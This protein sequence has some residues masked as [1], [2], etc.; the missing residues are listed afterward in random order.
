MIRSIWWKV[1]LLILLV[2]GVSVGLRVFGIDLTQ[3]T[4]DRVRG[5]VLSFGAL[6]PLIYLVAYG[7]PLI[8]LPASIMTIAG[9]LAFGPFWGMMAALAASMVRAC[10]Q[11]L[12][13][14]RL[15]REAVEKILRGK[16]AQFDQRIGDSGF[17]AVLLFRLIPNFPYDIQNYGLGFTK[18]TFRAFALATLI[19]GLPGTVVLVYFGYSLTDLKQLWKPLIAILAIAGLAVAQRAWQAKQRQPESG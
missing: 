13:A 15:G 1:G 4:P 3:I 6:A 5:F 12:I 11:F 2:A 19:G 16:L 7:Q 8:P 9:G 18:V 10:G 17:K 14:K